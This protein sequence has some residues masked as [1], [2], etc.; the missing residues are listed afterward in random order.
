M[1][2]KQSG[3]GIASL[4]L[5]IVGILTACIAIGAFPAILGIIF[6]VVAFTQKGRG[7]GTAI[8]GLICSIVAVIIFVFFM[9]FLFFDDEAEKTKK[10]AES[11]ELVDRGTEVEGQENVF[12][13][14]DIVETEKLKITLLSEESCNTNQ[15]YEEPKNGNTFC[16][17]DFE[18]ENI[19]DEDQE[20]ASYDFTCY[21]DDYNMNQTMGSEN[22]Y[23]TL[24]PGRKIKGSLYF[25]IP[26]DTKK[27]EIEYETEYNDD[28]KVCFEI[29]K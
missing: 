2:Q 24:S 1:V 4:V 29:D 10:T 28:A 21:A 17:L 9:M 12:H 13:I 6:A 22:L 27:I 25:E 19:S 14:G 16:K 8:A 15:Y 18:F 26:K 3:F 20:I 7:H 11:I 5:G 23:A